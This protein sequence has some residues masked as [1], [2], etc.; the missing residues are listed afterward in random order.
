MELENDYILYSA[1]SPTYT[2]FY[3]LQPIGDGTYEL[4]TSESDQKITQETYD[5]PEDIVDIAVNTLRQEK[6]FISAQSPYPKSVTDDSFKAFPTNK[7]QWD[8]SPVFGSIST[9][10]AADNCITSLILTD[11]SPSY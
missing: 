2:Y 9:N 6:L 10:V 11:F 5:L 8:N 4:S 7:Y 1:Q 3:S